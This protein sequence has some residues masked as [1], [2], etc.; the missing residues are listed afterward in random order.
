MGRHIDPNHSSWPSSKTL[1]QNCYADPYQRKTFNPPIRLWYFN[2]RSRTSK[3]ACALPT[4]LIFFLLLFFLETAH[5]I[6]RILPLNLLTLI[7]C[8][9]LVTLIPL[10]HSRLVSATVECESAAQ[11]VALS[12]MLHLIQF[13]FC[14]T[15]VSTRLLELAYSGC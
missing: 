2:V 6:K 5:F 10:S 11:S 13:L 9:F 12:N 8:L 14:H 3:L 15:I 1:V 7:F 4:R